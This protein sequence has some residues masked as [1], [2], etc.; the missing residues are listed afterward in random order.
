MHI[1]QYRLWNLCTRT[2]GKTSSLPLVASWYSLEKVFLLLGKQDAVPRTMALPEIKVGGVPC[3]PGDA[4]SP[5]QDSA[6]TRHGNNCQRV[7]RFAYSYHSQATQE[8]E[9]SCASEL[10]FFAWVPS[11]LA[12]ALESKY[13]NPAGEIKCD[14]DETF[15]KTAFR[16][17]EK[18][19]R[20]LKHMQEDD[21]EE[22]KLLA[23][24]IKSYS[25]PCVEWDECNQRYRKAQ[26]EFRQAQAG[27][28]S[29]KEGK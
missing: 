4:P 3:T 18:H 24:V 28:K 29:A 6:S 13:A 12:E 26:D 7:L 19:S 14:W 27:A 1:V 16:A 20:I 5:R 10:Y 9:I 8:V 23:Q 2:G 21:K 11:G 25:V 15:P 22:K 17:V